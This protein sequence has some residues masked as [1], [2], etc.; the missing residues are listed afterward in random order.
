[1]EVCN[2]PEIV[3]LARNECRKYFKKR[4]THQFQ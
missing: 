4:V 1:L 2:L 3:A